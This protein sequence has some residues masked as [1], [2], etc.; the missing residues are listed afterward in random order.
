MSSSSPPDVDRQATE[1]VFRERW[2]MWVQRAGAFQRNADDLARIV[3]ATTRPCGCGKVDEC[4]L[5]RAETTYYRLG[6]GV[7]RRS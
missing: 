4:L 1:A 7:R 5:C 3:F 2:E 6:G